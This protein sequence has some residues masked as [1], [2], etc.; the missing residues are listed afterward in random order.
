MTIHSALGKTQSL[1]RV[2]G[3]WDLVLLNVVAIVG[4]RWISV[5]AQIGPSSLMMWA[6][7]LLGFFVPLAFAVLELSSRLP[8]EG[9][10]YIWAKVAMGDLH[11]F[12][13]GWSYWVFNIVFFPSALLFSAGIFLHIV[14]G[15]W[16]DYGNDIAYNAAYCLT[17]LWCAIGLNI[18]G[19]ERAKWLQNIGGIATWTA[20]SLILGAGA[21]AWY[22]FGPATA[23]TSSNL[24]PDFSKLSTFSTL[25]T[26][27]LAYAGLELGP[28]IGGEIK[29]P[30]RQIPRATLISGVVVTTIYIAATASILI[31]LP[32]SSIDLIG[33]I[34]Q[35][36]TAVGERLG[37]PQFGRWT[38]LL[39]TLGTI[40][41]IA[42]FVTCTARL[43]FVVGVDRFLPQVLAR[44]HPKYGSP[45][46]ALLVQGVLTSLVLAAALSGSTIREAFSILIDMTVILSLIPLLY[47]FLAFPI[48]RKRVAGRNE[49]VVLSPGGGA[50]AWLVGL[51]G[52][53]CT[54][55]AIVTSMLPPA[56]SSSA[57]LFLFKVLGGSALL[58]G[59][60]LLFYWKG[61]K[62]SALGGSAESADKLETV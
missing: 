43:P 38:A 15:K 19:L 37:V 50:V 61:L 1:H 12:I 48:L 13:A 20:G 33:G 30:K 23:I 26:V 8:G 60:G 24:L 2:I 9:G 3:T 53:S 31:V 51:T 18:F 22:R 28:I 17:I 29:D 34:P 25:A 45:Y 55:L 49:G 7:G 11:G 5:A 40:G 46:V 36:L 14:G 39:I 42:A 59:V 54:T 47:I 4:L 32:T 56:D 35:A 10:L 62:H 16:L 57:S 52:F 58:I 6:I 44:L 41:S 21:V 27:M